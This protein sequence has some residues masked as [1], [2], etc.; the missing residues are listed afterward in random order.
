MTDIKT[1]TEIKEST[2]FNGSMHKYNRVFMWSEES[3]IFKRSKRDKKK[4]NSYHNHELVLFTRWKKNTNKILQKMSIEKRPPY[5]DP[6]PENP[7][8]PP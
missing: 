4:V 7:P 3:V 8:R 6:P 5:P 2:H 1:N